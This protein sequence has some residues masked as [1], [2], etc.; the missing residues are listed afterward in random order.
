[1]DLFHVLSVLPCRDDP[2]VLPISNPLRDAVYL[3]HD[4]GV[5]N[6][7]RFRSLHGQFSDA[8]RFDIRLFV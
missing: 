6:V 4:R 1:M 2:E 3:S 7:D 5:R 8:G